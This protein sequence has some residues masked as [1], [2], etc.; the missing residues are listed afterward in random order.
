MKYQ[1]AGKGRAADPPTG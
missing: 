1:K